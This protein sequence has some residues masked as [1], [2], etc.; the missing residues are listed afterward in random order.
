[1]KKWYLKIFL[2][3]SINLVKAQT[4]INPWISF[5][6]RKI[7]AVA[8]AVDNSGNIYTANQGISS[9]SKMT[10]QGQVT[11]LWAILDSSAIPNAI[12]VD[13]I[14]NIYTANKGNN[15]ISKISTQGLVTKSWAILD[16][17][18]TPF[19]IAIDNSGNLF[20]ANIENK[21]ISKI[22]SQGIVTKVFA[23]LDSSAI[24]SSIAIDHLG[25][26]FVNNSNNTISK[27]TSQGVVTKV[28]ANFNTTKYFHIEMATDKVG[29]VYTVNS[30]LAT[31]EANVFKI[32]ANGVITLLY[33]L[34]TNTYAS[35]FNYK[36]TIDKN[37]NIFVTNGHSKII[38]KIDNNG[39][40]STWATLKYSP[41][42]IYA[43]TDGYIYTANGNSASKVANYVAVN[44]DLSN[45]INPYGLFSD[46]SGNVYSINNEITLTKKAHT[47]SKISTNGFVDQKWVHLDSSFTSRYPVAADR[48]GNLYL[49]EDSLSSLYKITNTGNLIR[50]WKYGFD[51]SL[52]SITKISTDN[53]G[54][55]YLGYSLPKSIGY[56]IVKINN[57]GN[58]NTYTFS[59]QSI[60]GVNSISADHLGSVYFANSNNKINK[61]DA[62]GLITNNWADSSINERIASDKFG[63]VYGIGTRSIRK[64]SSNGKVT[65]TWSGFVNIKDFATD[66]LGNL[67][68]LVVDPNTTL[69]SINRIDKNGVLKNN[70]VSGF[71][72]SI[73]DG[74]NNPNHTMI[75]DTVLNKVYILNYSTIDAS[76]FIIK[77]DTCS[78][79][80]STPVI[81]LNGKKAICA[82]DSAILTSSSLSGNNWYLNDTLIKDATSTTLVAKIKGNYTLKT[83]LNG[84][85]SASSN[86][87]D[88]SI[89]PVPGIPITKDT[90]YCNGS[91][92][93]TLKVI[94]TSG[95]QLRWYGT[96]STGGIGTNVAIKPSSNLNG[97][98][99]YY[100]SQSNLLTGCEGPRAKINVTIKP[101]PIAP[102]LSRDL[103][104][105]LVANVAG[106]TW[107]KDGLI[108][109]DTTQ[110]LKP[111]LAGSYT[112]KTN[113]NGCLSAPSMP[114]YYIVTDIVNIST[115]EYI[116]LAPNPFS[117]QLNFDFFVKSYHRLNLEVYDLASGVRVASKSNLSTGM[118]IH[119]GQL[120]AGSYLIKVISI[121]NKISYQFKMVKL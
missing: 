20:T 116:K 114:Y 13:N 17:N 66:H 97:V 80:P 14:G 76:P 25:N 73:P 7:S 5:D 96:N 56:D 50:D 93:D 72:Y 61:I 90:F 32:N 28:W 85:S 55:L 78:T 3:F 100:V 65:Q 109:L 21:S 40:V 52:V 60:L 43:N 86:V 15:T 27:I 87:V 94:A 38:N 75:Y 69:S 95:N 101:V 83:L 48:I 53:L 71:K 42:F 39:F 92:T 57:S 47:I 81:N 11:K 74:L 79:I 36:I 119:L 37:Q 117:N 19:A 12:T 120:S 82:G 121:D 46:S 111:S 9:V 103:N 67:Y 107:Y 4:I 45:N 105:F 35:F 88:I 98:T 34:P 77:I 6:N 18:A 26:L 58:V 113:L 51:K 106:I 49:F 31:N 108:L 112:A 118:P 91:N 23:S 84:C 104:N 64:F 22:S 29:N 102:I 110:N 24:M 41:N 8:L 33:T 16:T 1:M 70:W 30:S 68:F 63:N 99:S 62:N 2:L 44:Y 115:D 59:H 54:N 10:Q 89:N